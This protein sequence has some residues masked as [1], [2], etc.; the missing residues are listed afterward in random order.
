MATHV[1]VVASS[2]PFVKLLTG[3]RAWP[4]PPFY[5]SSMHSLLI[6]NK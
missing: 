5:S 6:S 3:E 2:V 4:H 1:E